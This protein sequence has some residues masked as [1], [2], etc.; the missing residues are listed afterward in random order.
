MATGAGNSLPGHGSPTGHGMLISLKD[1]KDAADRGPIY[2]ML[3]LGA[4]A[5]AAVISV[6]AVVS[7]FNTAEFIAIIAIGALLIC[8]AGV[9]FLILMLSYVR[10]LTEVSK[11]S[12]STA[13][14]GLEVLAEAA[15]K[16]SQQDGMTQREIA[17]SISSMIEFIIRPPGAGQGQGQPELTGN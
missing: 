12:A 6:Q 3:F 15:D 13:T 14:K 7:K 5:I 1:L 11:G 17:K 10:T 2:V 8:G 16:L 4:S 9:L